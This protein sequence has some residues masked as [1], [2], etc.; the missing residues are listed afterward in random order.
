[1][2]RQNVVKWC[3]EIDAGRGDHDEMR[4]GRP[5]IVTDENI[6]KLMKTFVLTDV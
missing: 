2:K 5:S 1:M 6:Q 4:S 3:R